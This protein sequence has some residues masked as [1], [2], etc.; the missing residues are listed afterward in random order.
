MGNSQS[1]LAEQIHDQ[2]FTPVETAKWCYELAN[3]QLGWDFVGTALEPS[4]GAFAF[5]QAATELGLRLEWTT[6]DMFPQQD[7]APDHVSDFRELSLTGFDYCITNPPF[8]KANSLA[9]TFAKKGCEIATR[10][11]M[12]LPR[13]AMRMGFRD[14][15][16]RHNE[17]VIESLL[18]SEEFV[19][20]C[21]QTKIVKTCM[22]AWERVEY[23]VPTIKETLDLRTN[24]IE[25][26]GSDGPDWDT[27]K[28][29][30][31]FQIA[32]WGRMGHIF[33]P[34]KMKQ[35]GARISVVCKNISRDDFIRVHESID[36]EDFVEKSSNHPPA[37]DVP[38]WL[39]RFNQ[40][41][42]EL[43]LQPQKAE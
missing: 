3:N 42:A 5:V 23:R 15:M 35:S 29:P 21:G 43:G 25:H 24:L 31:D 12:V 14:A 36:L 33:S 2:Y 30:I 4:V 18:P 7:S 27:K 20:S 11:M 37:F 40:R 41:A 28:G 16:P 10:C 39:H 22:M 32:R 34:E 6:N 1:K 19:T 13:G 8:G 9:K 38:E 17:L 26:W